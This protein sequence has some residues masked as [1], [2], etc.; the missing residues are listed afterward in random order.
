MKLLFIGICALFLL[1]GYH[2]GPPPVE[3]SSDLS[4]ISSNEVDL[5]LTAPPTLTFTDPLSSKDNVFSVE[6]NTYQ[7]KFLENSE[8]LGIVA[9]GSSPLEVDAEK[10]EKL[11]IPQ[12]QQT[13][14]VSFLISSAIAPDKITVNTWDITLAG[15]D[16]KPSETKEYKS[17]FCISLEK[18]RIYE[19]VAVWEEKQYNQRNFSGE[20]SYILVTE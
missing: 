10:A 17:P 3:N 15:T 9:C 7:W 1:T 16:A 4:D 14:S 5:L 20:A 8:P 18:N 6:S 19:F 12:Y 13:E 2:Q 11:K